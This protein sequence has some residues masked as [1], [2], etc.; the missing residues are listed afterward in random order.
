MPNFKFPGNPQQIGRGSNREI[1]V[2]VDDSNLSTLDQ[3]RW[4]SGVVFTGSTVNSSSVWGYHSGRRCIV[5]PS[6]L[7]NGWF[8]QFCLTPTIQK[9]ANKG[10]LALRQN[11]HRLLVNM[12]CGDLSGVTNAN[13]DIGVDCLIGVPSGMSDLRTNNNTHLP[14]SSGMGVLLMLSGKWAFWVKQPDTPAGQ[15]TEALDLPDD[16]QTALNSGEWS[17]V[18][19]RVYDATATVEAKLELWINARKIL[20]R[21][22]V[23]GTDP[24]LPPMGNQGVGVTGSGLVL[25]LRNTSTGPPSMFFAWPTLISGPADAGTL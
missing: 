10:A 21:H 14:G 9:P 20:T 17:E 23:G 25:Q 8:S 12:A 11:V 18:E 15:V 1:D 24:L 22:W 13:S 4:R 19:F 5:V 3:M 6:G 2:T 16:I 7:G